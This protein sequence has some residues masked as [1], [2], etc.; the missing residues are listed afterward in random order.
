MHH[1][2][3]TV[4]TF[5]HDCFL[6]E[7]T[8]MESNVSP[9][10]TLIIYLFICL[11]QTKPK[12]FNQMKLAWVSTCDKCGTLNTSQQVVARCGD[13]C[14]LCEQKRAHVQSCVIPPPPVHT[15][16]CFPTAQYVDVF[17]LSPLK[18]LSQFVWL[19][20]SQQCDWHTCK[21]ENILSHSHSSTNPRGKGRG[22]SA[23]TTPCS[24]PG[25]N[26]S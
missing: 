14:T 9:T 26:P 5:D 12:A 23:L 7:V 15:N 16:V 24:T 21:L 4:N 10:L 19:F 3:L 22:C 6:N 13:V 2:L 1:F 17:L 11:N 20:S 18:R 8:M 25:I